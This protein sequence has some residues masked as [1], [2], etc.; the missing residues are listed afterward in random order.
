MVDFFLQIVIV[1]F[2]LAP[3]QEPD[4][5]F[6]K[7]HFSSSKTDKVTVFFLQISHVLIEKIPKAKE[8]S[9]THL[10]IE[11]LFLVYGKNLLQPNSKISILGSKVIPNYGLEPSAGRGA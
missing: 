7:N 3:W 1:G 11:L 10:R 9:L 5:F 6:K 8:K 2:G 4:L